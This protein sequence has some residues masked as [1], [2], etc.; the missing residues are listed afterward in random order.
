MMLNRLGS[1]TA[2]LLR[3]A[4]ARFAT[5]KT[6]GGSGASRTSNPK[7]LGIKI[8]GDQFAKPGA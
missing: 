5:K 6:G 4:L 1:L 7:Y 2:G 3:P 8:Y